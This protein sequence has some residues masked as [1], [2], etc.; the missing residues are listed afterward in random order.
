MSEVYYADCENEDCAACESVTVEYDLC[1]SPINQEGDNVEWEFTS[2]CIVC[3]HTHTLTVYASAH[4]F[5][6]DG[7]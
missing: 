1:E 2:E 3:G 7:E 4:H 6:L 5:Q